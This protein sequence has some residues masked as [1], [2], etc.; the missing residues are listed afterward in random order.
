MQVQGFIIVQEGP[1]DAV[2]KPQHLVPDTISRSFGTTGQVKKSTLKS[3]IT[4]EY[5]VY[6]MRFK[7]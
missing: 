7:S 4:D 5:H 1:Q 6:L 3:L 2:H